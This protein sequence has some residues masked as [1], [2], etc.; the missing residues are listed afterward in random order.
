ML[1]EKLQMLQNRMRIRFEEIRKTHQHSG[2]KGANVEQI[3]RDFLRE[4]LPPHNRIGHGEVIDSHDGV[5]QQTDVVVT[6]EHHPFLNDLPYPSV[7]IC[8]GVA[9]VGE[10]KS[11]LTS[12]DLNRVLVN[13][14]TFKSLKI[15]I[16]SGA[17][18]Y[19]NKEDLERFV[20][21][22]PFFLFAFESQLVIETIKQRIESWNTVNAVP[23][24]HQLDAVFILSGGN[25]VNFGT[26]GGTFQFVTP[27]GESLGGYRSIRSKNEQPLMAFLSWISATMPRVSLP[28]PPILSY[29]VKDVDDPKRV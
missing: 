29:L 6:N 27:K 13:T 9:C 14:Q 2:N 7:F 10:V 8:E 21:S 16:R 5:S 25:L 19:T 18:V 1:Q 24:K 17:T 11:V 20:D 3:V 22:R 15:Q 12:K 23:L 28:I 4:F 26:G